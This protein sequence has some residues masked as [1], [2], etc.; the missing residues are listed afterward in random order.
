MEEYTTFCDDTLKDKAYAIDTAEREIMAYDATVEDSNAQAA[1]LAD[2]ISTLGS[3]MAAKNGEL[4]DATKVLK[5]QTADFKAAESE[6]LVSIDQLGRAATILKRGMSFAQGQMRAK[7]MKEVVD[8]LKSV[9]EAAWVDV[10][11]KKKLHS[12]LQARASAAE[13]DDLSFSQPQA[14]TVAYESSS[15][16][17]LD[18]IKAMQGKA[19]DTLSSMRKKEMS[20]GNTFDMLKSGLEAELSHG[21]D[22]L[23]MAKKSKAANE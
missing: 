20:D 14:T 15:G 11:S 2:E 3:A 13:D 21:A 4:Y 5:E 1:A 23:S 22:K 6:L 17:I 19:E 12:F 18:T 10:S 9:I 7:K 8:A 16:G